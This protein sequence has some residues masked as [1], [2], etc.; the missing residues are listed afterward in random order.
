V[1]PVGDS[2]FLLIVCAFAV[3]LVIQTKRNGMISA[4]FLVF[5]LLFLWLYERRSSVS[6]S[7]IAISVLTALFAVVLIAFASYKTDP[8]WGSFAQTVEVALDTKAHKAWLNWDKYGAPLLQ[9]GTAVSHS[10]YMRIAWI[11]EGS[12][13]IADNPIGYG[14]GRNV[15][16]HAFAHKYGEGEGHSH[17]GLIDLGVGLGIVGIAIWYGMLAFVAVFGVRAYM[18]HKSYAGMLLFFIAVGFGSRMLIDSVNRD[19]MLE[20]FMFL[21]ALLFTLAAADISAK[22]E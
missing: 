10:N 4:A 5:Y 8:R 13:L 3:A 18:H 20:Q 9:D 7:K 15:C 19:H 17:S 2:L 21:T 6:K 22:K 11:K 14:Y 16:G 12:L 1:L